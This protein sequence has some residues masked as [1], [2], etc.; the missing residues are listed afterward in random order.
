MFGDG[1][2]KM[3]VWYGKEQN[4]IMP[5]L[6]LFFFSFILGSLYIKKSCI[7]NLQVYFIGVEE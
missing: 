3:Y 4:E 1:K 7:K 6:F 5:P 2:K